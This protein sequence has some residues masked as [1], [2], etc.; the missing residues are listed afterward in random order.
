VVGIAVGMLTDGQ[1]LNFAVPIDI[2][3]ELLSQRPQRTL[4]LGSLLEEVKGLQVQQSEEKF[5]SE[6]DSPY[7]KKQTELETLLNNGVGEAGGNADDLLKVAHVAEN[8]NVD[9]ATVAA[10]R[11]ADVRPSPDAYLLLANLLNA[12][13]A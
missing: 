2:L 1:N 13:Y 8:I 5:S 3:A 12:K 4:E 11:A 9:I 7:Q 10:R 6:T